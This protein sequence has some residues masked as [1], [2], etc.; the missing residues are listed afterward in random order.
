MVIKILREAL[1]DDVVIQGDQAEPKYL[2]DWTT[3][4]PVRPI[5][6]VRPYDTAQVATAVRI[7]RDHGIP[8]VPQG[9]RTGLVGGARPL[10]TGIVLSLDRMAGPP[11]ID[12]V[13]RV[14]WV[15]AGATL[16]MLEISARKEGLTFPVDFGA[17]GSCQIGGMLS[18]NAG[19]IRAFRSGMTRANVL[20]IEV[21]LPDGSILDA[22]NV[23]LKNNTGYDLKQLFI[24]AEGTLGIITSAVL[25]LAEYRP[26]TADVLLRVPD[27]ASAYRLLRRCERSLDGLAAFE[28]MWPDYY[29]YAVEMRGF[30]PLGA[31]EGLTLLVQTDGFDQQKLEAQMQAVLEELLEEGLLDDGAVAQTLGQARDFWSLREANEALY[32]RFP[33]LIGYD[34][35]ILPVHMD[36]LV[37]SV[38]RILSGYG[39]G[40]RSLW[41]GHLADMNLHLA[42]VADDVQS[43]TGNLRTEI[44][45]AVY[46][47]IIRLGGSI[48]AEHGIGIAKRK[49][50]DRFHS[51]VELDLMA[52]IKA[53]W[54]PQLIMNR[55]RL[56]PD[57]Q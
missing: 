56:L 27:V 38:R 52:G 24:G 40:Y 8:I 2:L 45:V 32:Q 42:I 39:R 15:Q 12:P 55:G 49:L 7:C 22:M 17:R 28:A 33:A 44:E 18:T 19:G 11:E 16:E 13:A 25:R 29:A 10:E 30:D 46:D 47:E 35:S 14:A 6:V 34:L 4:E 9:G 53:L 31:A 1:G 51:E 26:A 50:M 43:F 36:E 37:V 23:F 57:R 48:S 5:A 21:V 54:D 20:G 41:F 3:K